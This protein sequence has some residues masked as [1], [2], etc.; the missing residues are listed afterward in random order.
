MIQQVNELQEGDE[1][2]VSGLDLRY[3]T[4]LR[5]PE[6]RTK[7]TGWRNEINGYKSVKVYETFEE[8][9]LKNEPR[10]VYFDLNYKSAWLVK[11]KNE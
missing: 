1:I 6:V 9:G 7:A 11:R 2:I 8:V 4:V 3:F 10:I 5:K